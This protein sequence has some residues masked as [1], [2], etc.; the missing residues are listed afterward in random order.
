LGE[1]AFLINA[2]FQLLQL[3]RHFRFGYLYEIEEKFQ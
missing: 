1:K 3:H 2:I